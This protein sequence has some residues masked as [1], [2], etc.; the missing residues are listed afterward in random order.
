MNFG[1]KIARKQSALNL[2]RFLEIHAQFQYIYI[3]KVWKIL[4]IRSWRSLRK[5]KCKN[6]ESKDITF[7]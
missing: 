3:M 6:R 2:E 1:E 5:S 7:V 4:F